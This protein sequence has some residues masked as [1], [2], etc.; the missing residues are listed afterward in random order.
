MRRDEANS[1][2]GF[3][4]RTSQNISVLR[5]ERLSA[6]PLISS[7]RR[8]SAGVRVLKIAENGVRQDVRRG[9]DGAVIFDSIAPALR[10]L[11][12]ARR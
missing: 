10:S 3:L 9:W 7:K 5:Q 6:H 8:L 2:A 4:D 12:T 11:F 1:W